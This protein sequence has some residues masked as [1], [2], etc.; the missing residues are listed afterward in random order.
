MEDGEV[1]VDEVDDGSDRDVE[2]QDE[3]ET[4]EREEEQPRS[5]DLQRF[6]EGDHGL[7]GDLRPVV[8][9]HDGVEEEDAVGD[10]V[11]RQVLVVLAHVVAD[12]LFVG[13]GRLV[14]D[15]SAEEVHAEYRVEEHQQQH[16]DEEVCEQGDDLRDGFE[17]EAVLVG[18]LEQLVD[19]G[20]LRETHETPHVVDRLV[21]LGESSLL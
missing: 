18:E 7:G 20:D 14:R 13:F 2:H 16:L 4:E 21:V 10:V 15:E 8:G 11:E 17:D 12:H 6:L 5:E 9:D 1:G 3:A 19:R